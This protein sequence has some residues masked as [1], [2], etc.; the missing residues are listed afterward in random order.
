VVLIAA[1]G[2]RRRLGPEDMRRLLGERV[3]RS[4]ASDPRLRSHDA[5][6]DSALLTIGES[7]GVQIRFNR[8]VVES[9]SSST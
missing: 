2:L 7:E 6:D 1:T 3:S 5:S 8:R 9:D 4:F